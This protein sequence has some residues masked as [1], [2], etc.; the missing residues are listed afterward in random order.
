[1][2]KDLEKNE[3]NTNLTK[4]LPNVQDALLGASHYYFHHRKC[5]VTLTAFFYFNGSAGLVGYC[6]FL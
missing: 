3:H 5:P 6:L 4:C 2:K 1:M